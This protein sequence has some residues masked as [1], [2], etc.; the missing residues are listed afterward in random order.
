M[1]YHAVPAAAACAHCLCQLDVHN[2][3]YFREPSIHTSSPCR[4]RL[5][6]RSQHIVWPAGRARTTACSALV[7]DRKALL[8]DV[9][10]SRSRP[11]RR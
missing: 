6:Q 3:V 11:S 5:L 9:R 7:E 8:E 4:A 2:P 10:D 1:A